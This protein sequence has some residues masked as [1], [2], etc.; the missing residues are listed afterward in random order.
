MNANV[1]RKYMD[2]LPRWLMR[3]LANLYV[4]F[5]GTGI[6]IDYVAEDWREIRVSLRWRWWTRNYVGTQWGG[7]IYAM[8][9]PFY[10]LMIMNLIGRDYICWDKE[11][12]IKF[13][14]PGRSRLL[15]VFTLDAAEIEQI[16]A[17]VSLRGKTLFSK[18]VQIK[19][20]QG[21]LIAEV[22]KT[23]YIKEK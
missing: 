11:A 3:H 18:S 4:P 22:L 15:A 23:V 19:D 21:E 8:T 6:T 2:H 9:D 12:Q 14:K 1:L 16:K 10:M 13:I 20:K 17:D 5:L 7:S